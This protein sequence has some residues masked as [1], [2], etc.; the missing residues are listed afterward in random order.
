MQA[1]HAAWVEGD[2]DGQ[3]WMKE[4]KLWE[5]APKN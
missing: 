1:A 2:L 5:A 3:L 4:Q